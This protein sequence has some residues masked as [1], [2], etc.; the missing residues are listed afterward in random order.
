MTL[1]AGQVTLGLG[2]TLLHQGNSRSERG[3]RFLLRCAQ[4]DSLRPKVGAMTETK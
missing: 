1:L 3:G 4:D 2:V